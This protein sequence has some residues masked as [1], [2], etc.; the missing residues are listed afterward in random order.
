MTTHLPNF[1]EIVETLDLLEDWEDRYSFIIDL[2][3][4]NPPL[5]EEDKNALNLVEGC[6]SQVW[7]THAVL[8]QTQNAAPIL[9]FKGDSDAFIVRGLV[10]LVLA[11]YSGKTASEILALDAWAVFKCLGLAEHLS[12]QRAN[13]VRAVIERI[14][15]TA[16]NAL[17]V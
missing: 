17:H 11:L 14:R 1:E 3:K 15:R 8:S 12:S 9:S 4:K 10:A 5:S 6:A 13:G 16:H 2:G 7:I